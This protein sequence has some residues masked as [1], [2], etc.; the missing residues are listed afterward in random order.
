MSLTILTRFVRRD[1]LQPHVEGLRREQVAEDQEDEDG[2]G[3]ARGGISLV[4]VV[5]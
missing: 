2:E 4:F 1:H 3:R 5:R